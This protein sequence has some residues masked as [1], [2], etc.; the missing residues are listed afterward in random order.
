MMHILVAILMSLCFLCACSN[1]SGTQAPVTLSETQDPGSL[2]L[3]PSESDAPEVNLPV[4]TPFAPAESTAVPESSAPLDAQSPAETPASNTPVTFPSSGYVNREGVNVRKEGSTDASIVDVL[5]EN[6]A[7]QVTALENEWYSVE[8][9]GKTGY[10]S[11]DLVTIG[12][13]PRQDN[14]HYVK[15]TAATAKLYKSPSN[16]EAS[17]RSLAKDEI[18]RALRTIN[19]YTH[20]VLDDFLQRYV[21]AAEVEVVPA[22]EA[23]AYFA[24]KTA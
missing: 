5:G 4:E 12:D 15:V 16:T 24:Q 11:A 2:P 22:A 18:V 6:V 20:V 13:A 17:E 3:T 7:L 14:M 10:I 8:Y 9:D 23:E 19:G 1:G 21:T